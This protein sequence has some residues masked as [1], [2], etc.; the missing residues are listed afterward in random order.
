MQTKHDII[1]LTMDTWTTHVVRIVIRWILMVT[2]FTAKENMFVNKIENI[3]IKKYAYYYYN[4][5]NE[6]TLAYLVL[7][8]TWD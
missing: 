7:L 4:V 3:C 8:S 2:Q 6:Y 1:I 5:K